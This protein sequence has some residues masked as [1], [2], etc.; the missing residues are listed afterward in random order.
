MTITEIPLNRF[1]IH[2]AL[3]Q[4]YGS[5]LTSDVV[6]LQFENGTQTLMRGCH[7]MGNENTAILYDSSNTRSTYLITG[8][9]KILYIKDYNN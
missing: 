5:G 6:M 7:T 4:A 2:R 9:E 3:R 1:D 8:T